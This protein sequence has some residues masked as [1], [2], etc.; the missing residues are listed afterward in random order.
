MD[1]LGRIIILSIIDVSIF[2][3]MVPGLELTDGSSV[4]VGVI[5]EL[6]H[7]ACGH[8]DLEQKVL[9]T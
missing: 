2:T 3:S 6:E 9:M 7:E 5:H 4:L 1:A 8:S